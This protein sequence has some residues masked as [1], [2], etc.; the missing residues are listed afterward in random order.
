MFFLPWNQKRTKI[1]Y[2]NQKLYLP[3]CQKKYHLESGTFNSQKKPF[4]SLADSKGTVKAFL[5]ALQKD[6]TEEA[7]GYLSRSVAGG[8]DMEEIRRFFSAGNS[9]CFFTEEKSEKVRTVFLASSQQKEMIF[10]R[11]VTEPD[12]YGRWKIYEIEKE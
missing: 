12:E 11:L 3:V 2:P 5:D 4:F 1:N 7:K 9:Y 6:R 10:L 8:A